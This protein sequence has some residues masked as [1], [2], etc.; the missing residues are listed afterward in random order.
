MTDIPHVTA[1][2]R[3]PVTLSEEVTRI[4]EAYCREHDLYIQ[5]FIR[6]TD[7]I[8]LA[9]DWWNAGAP[10]RG[11]ARIL[12]DGQDVSNNALSRS[13]TASDPRN[14]RIC[15]RTYFRHGQA[16]ICPMLENHEGQHYPVEDLTGRS[17][18]LEIKTADLTVLSLQPGDVILLRVPMRITV[19]DAEH[20]TKLLHD[21]LPG[22]KVMFL[23]GGFELSVLRP[24]APDQSPTAEDESAG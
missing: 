3:H 20:I 21:K 18:Q 6:D 16:L 11:T 22:H 5:D 9:I 1:D 17:T 4:T 24:D 10:G 23:E 13:M 8:N 12:I 14:D 7:L 2:W 15:G 19:E